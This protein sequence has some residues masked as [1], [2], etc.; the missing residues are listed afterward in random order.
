[1]IGKIG[2]EGVVD[3]ASVIAFVGVELR[4]GVGDDL[5]YRD[6]PAVG[7]VHVVE[8]VDARLGRTTVGLDQVEDEA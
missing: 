3:L 6:R 4:A 8:E 7:L 2:I 5:E 1:M